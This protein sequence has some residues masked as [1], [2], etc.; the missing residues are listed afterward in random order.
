MNL[1]A[2]D[3]STP[4]C[5]V[6]LLV[7]Q[8]VFARFDMMPARHTEVLIPWVESLL[9][10][11]GI[12]RFDLDAIGVAIGPGTFTGVRLAISVAQ[13]FAFGL[14]RP[15]IPLSTLHL[16]ALQAPP[17]AQNVLACLDARMGEVYCGCY[18]R[19]DS[20]VL[21][22]M[23]TESV[24][25]PDAFVLPQTTGS[26][27]ALGSG[28]NVENKL[29]FQRIN[30]RCIEQRPS[31][32]PNAADML[33]YASQVLAQGQVVDPARVEPIYLRQR[34]AWTLAERRSG[35]AKKSI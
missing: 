7:G 31:A 13:G 20:G 30:D 1:L 9:A 16:L 21:S 4:A 32:Y 19:D 10:E 3:T 2:I 6:A 24:C 14:H 17:Y 15:V 29:L 12:R 34:V 28:L 8:A 11:A 22:L 26:W 5:S 23:I 25:S 18:R 27:F 33:P 35:A